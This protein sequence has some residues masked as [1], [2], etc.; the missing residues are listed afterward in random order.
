M[1]CVT[2]ALAQIPREQARQVAECG[3]LATLAVEQ[4]ANAPDRKELFEDVVQN[5]VDFTSLYFLMSQG[6]S[7]TTDG[8]ITNDMLLEVAAIGKA[9]HDRR[10]SSMSRQNALR[11]SNRVLQDCRSDLQEMHEKLEF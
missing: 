10:I 6:V 11:L 9:E 5:V 2:P 7:P 4:L 8:T 1:L 3:Y